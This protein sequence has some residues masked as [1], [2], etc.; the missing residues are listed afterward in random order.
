[1]RCNRRGSIALRILITVPGQSGVKSQEME[2]VLSNATLAALARKQKR[3]EERM[4]LGAPSC[5][6]RSGLLSVKDPGRVYQLTVD[7]ELNDVGAGGSL[8][9]VILNP[10]VPVRYVVPTLQPKVGER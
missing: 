10:T 6:G 3:A 7:D 2:R 8:A 1:M 5:F 4:P 9:A